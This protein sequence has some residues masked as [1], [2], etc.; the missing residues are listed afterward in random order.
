MIR[1]AMKPGRALNTAPDQGEFPQRTMVA[2]PTAII[3][4]AKE[5][6]RGFP[7]MR[8][9]RMGPKVAPRADQAIRT[10]EKTPE[11]AYSAIIRAR[12]PTPRVAILE[13]V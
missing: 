11:S 3:N 2:S 10:R 4:I 1:G 12:A 13:A 6:G 5:L 9:T 8:M 7:A